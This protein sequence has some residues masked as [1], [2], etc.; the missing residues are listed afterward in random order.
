MSRSIAPARKIFLQ[1]SSQETGQETLVS[2]Y[3]GNFQLVHV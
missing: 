2:I 1:V 3:P